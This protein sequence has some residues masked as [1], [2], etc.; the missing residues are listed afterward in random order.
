MRFEPLNRFVVARVT[1]LK[2]PGKNLGQS[3]PDTNKPT[4]AQASQS[5]TYIS[6]LACHSQMALCR[7]SS[8][9]SVTGE[10]ASP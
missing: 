9:Y 5:F 1:S 6:A 2:W 7:Y 10:D 4:A 8:L 3:W